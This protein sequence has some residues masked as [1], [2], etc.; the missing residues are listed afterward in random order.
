[1]SKNRT[2]FENNNNKKIL[3]G[4]ELKKPNPTQTKTKKATTKNPTPEGF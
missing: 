3:L 2:V 1:M 4:N